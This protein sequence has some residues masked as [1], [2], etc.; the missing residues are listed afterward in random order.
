MTNTMPNPSDTDTASLAGQVAL[1]T[2]GG[3]GIGHGTALAL[4]KAGVKIAV[5]ARS[6]DELDEKR[7]MTRCT[8]CSTGVT[9]LGCAASNRRSGMGNERTHWRT[10]TRGLTWSTRCAAVWAMRLAPRTR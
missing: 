10:G 8:T 5:A 6:R 9:S 1:I 4:S 2:G 3:R 7:V